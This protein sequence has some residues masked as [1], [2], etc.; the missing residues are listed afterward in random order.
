MYFI[1]YLNQ[2]IIYF[3]SVC[4]KS[5]NVNSVYF[6]TYVYSDMIP[7][8]EQSW[9]NMRCSC[10]CFPWCKVQQQRSS[11]RLLLLTLFC[12]VN[13][14]QF[15]PGLVPLD[16]TAV[17]F[18]GTEVSMKQTNKTAERSLPL[19]YLHLCS[20]FFLTVRMDSDVQISSVVSPELVGSY[21]LV[22]E[23]CQI[24]QSN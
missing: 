15:S 17:T 11:C 3:I 10:I 5:S 13:C 2:W 18:Q 7:S 24:F 6:T 8:E 16:C 14:W 12:L 1:F 23:W 9:Y 21:E 19:T 4:F 20:Y 22:L